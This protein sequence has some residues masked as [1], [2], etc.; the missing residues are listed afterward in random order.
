VLSRTFL[1][2]RL[3]F[4]SCLVYIHETIIMPVPVD[5]YPL[6][7]FIIA[8]NGQIISVSCYHLI[9]RGLLQ[10]QD[11]TVREHIQW[12]RQQIE[13]ARGLPSEFAYDDPRDRNSLCEFTV[14]PRDRND[15]LSFPKV[16]R[17]LD[18]PMRWPW[19]ATVSLSS[20]GSIASSCNTHPSRWRGNS[21][22]RRGTRCLFR[23]NGTEAEESIC[24]RPRGVSGALTS[25][26]PL[27]ECKLFKLQDHRLNLR[28]TT[29]LYDSITLTIY[30]ENNSC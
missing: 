27:R 7:K 1:E 17:N 29:K 30:R 5:P 8:L 20:M 23:T 4:S 24:K 26:L 3:L 9:D 25:V 6:R 11:V 2:C 22:C 19:P 10:S 14:E 16:H 21:R 12:V 15:L 28:H 18:L 13:E